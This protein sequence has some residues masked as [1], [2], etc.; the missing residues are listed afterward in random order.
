MIKDIDF[1]GSKPSKQFH[2]VHPG[3]SPLPDIVFI[4]AGC[5]HREDLFSAG[6]TCVYTRKSR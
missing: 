3:A 4:N 1:M 6:Y 2:V 5:P